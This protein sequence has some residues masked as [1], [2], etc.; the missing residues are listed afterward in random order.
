M[1]PPVYRL[2]W[3]VSSQ[4]DVGTASCSLT[5]RDGDARSRRCWIFLTLVVA[6]RPLPLIA[7]SA[8]PAVTPACAAIDPLTTER[9]SNAEQPSCPR[10][11]LS[12][13]PT[14][15]ND[16]RSSRGA[17]EGDA[18]LGC[19]GGDDVALGEGPGLGL[20]GEGLGVEV[21]GSDLGLGL[22]V[23]LGLGSG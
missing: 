14:G 3:S 21:L 9:T 2:K 20:G 23:G 4:T 10:E 12:S 13:M 6:A 5:F 18:F 11:R 17:G 16:T 19:L 1:S 15:A 8:I 7:R 22:G